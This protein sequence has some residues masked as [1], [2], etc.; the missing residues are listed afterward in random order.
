[1]FTACEKPTEQDQ[2]ITTNF[3][4]G[5]WE[6]TQIHCIEYVEGELDEEWVEDLSD[7]GEFVTFKNDGTYTSNMFD[8]GIY[9]FEDET[10]IYMSTLVDTYLSDLSSSPTAKIEKLSANSFKL[11]CLY[12]EENYYQLHN[13]ITFNRQ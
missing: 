8:S 11:T 1:M 6:P 3:L 5:T 13:I 10:T 7:E 4:I 2:T 9:S 12:E